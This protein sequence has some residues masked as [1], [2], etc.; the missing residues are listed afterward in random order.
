MKLRLLFITMLVSATTWVVRAQSGSSCADAIPF[1]LETP[2][3]QE[4]A[5]LWYYVQLTEE[6]RGKECV[7]TLSTTH[8]ETI[9]ITADVYTTCD[10][11]LFDATTVLA[12][13]QTK[14]QTLQA[15]LVNNVLDNYG[16]RAYLKIHMSGGKIDFNVETR[17]P[18]IE[19]E[20]PLCL[21]A[22]EVVNNPA[23]GQNDTT[24]YN[25][26]ADQPT[27]FS[28]T[29]EGNQTI[30]LYF[31]P[32]SPADKYSE[33][34]VELYFDCASDAQYVR[35]GTADTVI[36]G[37]V[38]PAG[39]YYAKFTG[40]VNGK[41][42]FVVRDVDL[43]CVDAETMEHGMTYTTVAGDN[44]YRF[45]TD[46]ATELPIENTGAAD[47]TITLYEGVCGGEQTNT[48]WRELETV[49]VAPGAS[50]LFDA[51]PANA[52]GHAYYLKVNG[53]TTL[54]VGGGN[55]C[56]T[57]M[58]L[59]DGGVYELLPG[60]TYWY[61]YEFDGKSEVKATFT[62][63]NPTTTKRIAGYLDCE[64]A[65]VFA[66]SFTEAVV[67]EGIVMPSGLYYGSIRVDA[68]CTMTIDI[69]TSPTDKE[70]A[71][72]RELNYGD[73][74]IAAGWYDFIGDGDLTILAEAENTRISAIYRMICGSTD[75]NHQVEVMSNI[76]LSSDEMLH[77]PLEPLRPGWHYYVVLE[78]GVFSVINGENCSRALVIEPG[79][80]YRMH[81]GRSVWYTYTFNGHE[82]MSVTYTPDEA[83]AVVNKEAVLYF[84]CGEAPAYTA[85]T[86]ATTVSRD[87]VVP[88]GTYY[89]KLTADKDGV[90]VFTV[91]EVTEACAV[92]DTI[93][94]ANAPY[95]TNLTVNAEKW[96]YFEPNP[97]I[98]LTLEVV[99]GTPN[100]SLY[101]GVCNVGTPGV[102]YEYWHAVFE[103][104]T[105][106]AG[107]RYDLLQDPALQY[108]GYYF[109]VTNGTIRFTSL[110]L[111]GRT[112]E[113]AYEIEAGKEYLVEDITWFVLTSDGTQSFG[114]DF[115]PVLSGERVTK[116]VALFFDCADTEPIATRTSTANHVE[117]DY[118]V[119]AGTYYLRLTTTAS[120]NNAGTIVF[121][122]REEIPCAVAE[123]IVLGQ[124][125]TQTEGTA[126]Y[127]MGD[128]VTPLLYV[129]TNAEVRVYKGICSSTTEDRN[130][131]LAVDTIRHEAKVEVLDELIFEDLNVGEY[132]FEVVAQANDTVRF[133]TYMAS[134]E[135]SDTVC[136]GHQ[137]TI[138]TDVY[139]IDHDMTIRD[140]VEYVY[141]ARPEFTLDSLYIYHFT[142]YRTPEIPD[143]QLWPEAICGDTLHLGAATEAAWQ[144]LTASITPEQSE[145]ADAW[146]EILN[147]SNNTYVRYAGEKTA[148]GVE[149]VT[150]RY[151]VKTICE[152]TVYSEGKVLTVGI[153][154]A[155]N[156]EG[157]DNVP[158]V[159]KYDWLLMLNVKQLQEKGYEF[160]EEDVT[161]YRVK[162][163][164][165]ILGSDEADDELLGKG[166][167]YTIGKTFVGSGDYYATVDLQPNVT[168]AMCGGVLRTQVFS[169][170]STG[171]E[172]VALYP[173]MLKSGEQVNVTGLPEDAA[174]EITIY[175]MMGQVLNRF[176]SKGVATYSFTTQ[177][178]PGYY[179]V[180]VRFED[181]EQILKY[182]VK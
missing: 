175:D 151:A 89:A 88:A 172:G 67:D 93:G 86:T 23:N 138:G 62:G 157:Y 177:A 85:T 37:Y 64:S 128:D 45:Y 61:K 121:F 41:A 47:V 103:N 1:V 139:T 111:G 163:T 132:Y 135:R 149:T 120:T 179:M 33:K 40:T 141:A 22:F 76:E 30:D 110:T 4:T 65:A 66:T 74:A 44:W 73:M 97:S 54:S 148:P 50:H 9:T 49:T 12:P 95:E 5:E 83:G 178:V 165:D 35:T 68:A 105:M 13:G 150:V 2:F 91:E 71:Y 158:A 155:D 38:I 18:E 153:P 77:I 107:T 16:G 7:L 169:F 127:K 166:Y 160:T 43:P 126:W 131:W 87:Y 164:K 96:F 174:V 8:T 60:Q 17:I 133:T 136:A 137:V 173:N 82:K 32:T 116:E 51:L 115:T 101:K 10:N 25:L 53:I 69:F 167:Y 118:V 98:D 134:A 181:K 123:D 81:A 125:Y 26:V 15:G 162:G 57:A 84:N 70:C 100:V 56:A 114:A 99:S 75:P 36:R 19:T 113:D 55:S 20:D 122:L 6:E 104:Q 171:R 130:Y 24:K 182:V 142:T 14:T 90:A 34:T 146:W 147:V 129:E 108:G 21:E 39:T 80:E 58:W 79:K 52:L 28:F 152:E 42:T 106:S 154:T 119:P 3:V 176:H 156:F 159:S 180:Q 124:T 94:S 161:W 109:K 117:L 29:S 78:S 145:P 59:V 31:Q 144:Q 102:D 11:K 92:A 143:L 63:A 170:V 112:C 46:Y 72:A 168:E 27:W 140:T 48:G